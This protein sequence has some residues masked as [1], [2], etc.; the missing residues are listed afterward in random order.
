MRERSVLP[1][2]W[3]NLIIIFFF[4]SLI[5]YIPPTI[6]LLLQ[7]EKKYANKW[8]LLHPVCFFFITWSTTATNITDCNTCVKI[9][10]NEIIY[11]KWEMSPASYQINNKKKSISKP[12]FRQ[13]T[14]KLKRTQTKIKVWL[15]YLR[16]VVTEITI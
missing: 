5:Y 14:V 16:G 8:I 9:A 15:W 12:R 1:R 3:K 7:H 13:I 10:T 6:V 2:C 11:T 4:S